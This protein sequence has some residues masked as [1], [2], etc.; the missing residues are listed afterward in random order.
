MGE[1]PR[2]LRCNRSRGGNAMIAHVVASRSVARDYVA[3]TKPRIIPLLLVTAL[4][5][6]FLA[7][8][9]APDA[10]LIILVLK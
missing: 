5:G 6:M 2:P 7:A 8:R 9:G 1:E 10:S 4:G 3:L